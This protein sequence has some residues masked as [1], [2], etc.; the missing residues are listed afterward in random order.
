MVFFAQT[1]P[2][3]VTS[4]FY[5]KRPA[6]YVTVRAASGLLQTIGLAV[7]PVILAFF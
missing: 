1:L 4:F 5:E 2:S 6:G 3:L 7:H